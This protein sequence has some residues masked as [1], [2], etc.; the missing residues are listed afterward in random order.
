[1]ATVK[2]LRSQEEIESAFS[3]MHQLRNHLDENTYV[4]LVLEAQIKE[5]YRL[6][7]LY[8]EDKIVAVIGFM[9]MITLNY[10]RFIWVCDLVTDEKQRHLGYG[11]QL[12]NYVH[13]WAEDHKYRSVALSSGVDQTETH[14]FYE[15]K[16]DYDKVSYVFTKTLH[17]QKESPE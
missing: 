10:G 17:K 16:M 14:R 4:E 7:A 8:E 1:M 3:I 11:E 5:Q 15:E 13:Q 12:L 9:P 6:C 2:E